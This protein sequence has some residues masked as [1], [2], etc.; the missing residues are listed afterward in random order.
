MYQTFWK[1]TK[2][3]K[4]KQQ[5][6]SRKNQKVQKKKKKNVKTFFQKQNVQK[7]LYCA[8]MLTLFFQKTM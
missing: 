8:E 3:K 4:K 7:N 6:M 1:K 2:C 5:K